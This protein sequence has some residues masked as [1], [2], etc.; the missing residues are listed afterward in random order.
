LTAVVDADSLFAL[1]VENLRDYAVLVLDLEGRIAAWNPGAERILGY[2]E[3]QAIGQSAAI[4]FVPEDV[5]AG[6]VEQELA[7]ARA[8]GRAEDERWHIRSDG[9]RFWAS[10]VLTSVRDDA[11]ELRCFAK[12]LRDLTERKRAEDERQALFDVLAHDLKNPLAAIMGQTQ[13]LKR[14]LARGDAVAPEQLDTLIA[15]A[16]RMVGQ[17]DDVVA[18]A[19]LGIGVAPTF[20]PERFDLVA[21]VRRV[22]A[23]YGGGSDRHSITIDAAAP[24]LEI[25]ADPTG[26]ERVVA[27]LVAN[28][29]K[30]SPDGGTIRIAVHVA[31]TTEVPV[32]ELDVA[33]EGI[34]IPAEDLAHVFDRG[35]RGRNVGV[36]P[37]VGLGLEGVRRIVEQ[38]GGTVTVKSQEGIGSTFTVRL[39]LAPP[40]SSP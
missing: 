15:A 26:I 14:R 21:Q 3:E 7:T 37:G 8:L 36:V 10:G 24:S 32:A 28:A 31:G 5:A 2:R 19:R 34:G 17:I 18:S 12:V 25:V 35:R 22:V 9:S 4:I 23:L 1:V 40:A 30:Y 20:V 16:T 29:L 33:D 38:H 6:A 27:N 39:P 13:L 11:G